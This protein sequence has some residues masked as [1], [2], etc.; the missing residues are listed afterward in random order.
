MGWV[1][2]STLTLLG[3][4][5][6]NGMGA[7][8]YPNPIAPLPRARAPGRSAAPRSSG[9]ASLRRL[10]QCSGGSVQCPGQSRRGLGEGELL[11][12]GCINKVG[13]YLCIFEC[14]PIYWGT[15]V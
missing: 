9:W 10:P 7:V 15:P 12:Q 4:S 6:C 3:S 8:E 2:L 14:I 11:Q 13:G 5:S 1:L